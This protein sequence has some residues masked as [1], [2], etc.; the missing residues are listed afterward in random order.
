MS[1][2]SSQQ[3]GRELLVDKV[4][5]P[6]QSGYASGPQFSAMAARSPEKETRRPRVRAT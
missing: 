6:L 3:T 4:V 5:D 1:C 2:L